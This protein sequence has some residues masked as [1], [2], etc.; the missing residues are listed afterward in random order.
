MNTKLIEKLKK[1]LALAGNNPSQAEAELAMAKAQALALEH[2]ID[3]ALAYIK[4][5]EED[6]DILMDKVDMGK[7][8]PTVNTYVSTILCK[9]FNVKIILSGGRYNGRSLV[10][11]GSREAIDTAKYV[12]TWLSDTMVRCWHN[13]YH[14]ANGISL[15]HKQSYLLGFYRGL[16]NK[17]QQNK[18]NVENEKLTTVGDKNKYAVAC[19]N[20]NE[21]LQEFAEETFPNLRKGPIKTINIHSNSYSRG[22]SDGSNCNIAKGGISN[23]SMGLIA[24]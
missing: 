3:I 21:K 17:L 10:Y 7:R 5:E 20:L 19:I 1:L 14:N 12:Y 24:A 4:E 8:L 6:T 22:Q 18:L 9:F 11:I 23:R 2:G 16:D 15:D 13:Y